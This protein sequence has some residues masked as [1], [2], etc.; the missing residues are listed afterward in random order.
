MASEW[1][2]WIACVVVGLPIEPCAYADW[3]QKQAEF[4]V[5]EDP[6][7]RSLDNA[8]VAAWM[9][10]TLDDCRKKGAEQRG[11]IQS[12]TSG[13]TWRAGASTCSISRPASDSAGNRTRP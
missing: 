8:A 2:S 9:A 13:T 12:T 5:N 6:R 4:Q 11:P 1:A 3:L 10:A 7:A